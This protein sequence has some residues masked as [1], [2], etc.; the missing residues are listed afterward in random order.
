MI[1]F[2]LPRP[3]SKMKAVYFFLVLLALPNAAVG[4][5]RRKNFYVNAMLSWDD[6]QTY[7]RNNYVDMS[8][9]DSQ[10]AADDLQTDVGQNLIQMHW[11]GLS[12]ARNETFFTKWSDGTPFRFSLWGNLQPFYPDPHRCVYASNNKWTAYGCFSMFPFNCYVWD[13]EL[14][15]V[16]EMKTWEEA[17]MHCRTFYTDLVSLETETDLFQVTKKSFKN[18]TSSFWTGLRNID[19]KWF[20]VNRN[21]L[22]NFIQLPSCTPRPS[23]CGARNIQANVWENRDCNEKKNFICYKKPI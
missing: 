21:S 2:V 1:N 19:G 18:D 5:F 22:G 8:T 14:I 23:G 9:I 20:W 7:C 4:L 16:R 10:E 17:L 15:V 11:I 13:S 12:Q 3:C 6:A